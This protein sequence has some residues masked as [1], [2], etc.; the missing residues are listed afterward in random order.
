MFKNTSHNVFYGSGS[1]NFGITSPGP[2]NKSKLTRDFLQG[3]KK[4][5]LNRALV[6]AA[7]LTAFILIWTRTNG[8][9]FLGSKENIGCNRTNNDGRQTDNTAVIGVQS[10]DK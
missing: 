8:D 3:T 2:N 7:I 9:R 6:A 5:P 10:A 4:I 1:V